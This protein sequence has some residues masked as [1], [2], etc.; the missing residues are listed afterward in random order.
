MRESSPDYVFMK[1]RS[2]DEVEQLETNVYTFENPDAEEGAKRVLVTSNDPGSFN[3][4]KH[5]VRNLIA[6]PRCRGV[7]AL[8][9]GNAAENFTKEF[10]RFERVREQEVDEHGNERVK[11]VF[12]D[13]G[14]LAEKRPVDVALLSLSTRDGP[15]VPMLFAGKDV[16]GAR[17]TFV[18]VDG[19]GKLEGPFTR[20]NTDNMEHIDGIFCNDEFEKTLIESALPA[21]PPD[22]I[23]PYG[24]PVFEHLELDKAAEYRSETRKKLGI[25]ADAFVVLYVGDVSL[26][27]EGWKGVDSTNINIQTFEKTREALERWAIAHP[28]REVVLLVRPHG[29]AKKKPET[30]HDWDYLIRAADEPHSFGN[31]SLRNASGPSMNEVAY[32]ADAVAS[33]CSTENQVAPL[34]GLPAIYLGYGEEGLGKEVLGRLYGSE[35]LPRLDGIPGISIVSSENDLQRALDQVA[36]EH[37]P[38]TQKPRKVED[39]TAR[40]VDA[41]LA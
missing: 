18:L 25:G 19:W 5:V 38:E 4:V 8:I 20:T 26:D 24:T 35:N 36:T 33:I 34:R 11:S 21:Y 37:A 13:V 40:I 39:S 12:E 1:Q 3:A 14:D 23:H 17:K 28:D 10:P 41:I 32:T 22:Y 27:Y 7:T 15:E 9:S 29:R 6:N 16:F 30:I 2:D 31:F